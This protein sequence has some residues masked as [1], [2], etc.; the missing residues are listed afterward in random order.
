MENIVRCCLYCGQ[1]YAHTCSRYCRD[2][3]ELEKIKRCSCI[4]FQQYIYNYFWISL[5]VVS[6]IMASLAFEKS[7][8]LFHANI[9]IYKY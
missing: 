7:Q 3:D 8:H 9:L 4:A 5:V 2:L 6:Q 1:C